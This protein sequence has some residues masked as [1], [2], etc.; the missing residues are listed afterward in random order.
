MRPSLATIAL[1]AVTLLLPAGS[2]AREIPENI[3]QLR[4]SIIAK[5]DCR[6]KLAS[7]FRI[8]EGST[9]STFCRGDASRP[10]PCLASAHAVVSWP[11][12]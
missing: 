3:R 10:H 6:K 9:A 7:G 12:R 4:D 11:S 8:Q 5:G 1:S 2:S